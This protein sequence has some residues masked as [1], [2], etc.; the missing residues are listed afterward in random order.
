MFKNDILTV[1]RENYEVINNLATKKY[2]T[3]YENIPC[4]LAINLNNTSYSQNVPLLNSEFTIYLNFDE[5]IQIKEN[6]KLC[7]VTS[8]GEIYTLYAG[9][10]KIYNFS[11]QIK[12]R[13]EKIIESDFDV[14]RWD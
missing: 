6:D 10:V 9:G 7:V 14:N 8:K 5:K 4:H 3:V 13:Q 1:K 12:C 11:I 2:E